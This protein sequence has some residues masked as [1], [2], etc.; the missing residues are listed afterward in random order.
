GDDSVGR[1]IRLV[2][3]LPPVPD[4]V[5]DRARTAVRDEWRATLAA[6]RRRRQALAGS[7]A[8]SLLIALGVG[9]WVQGPVEP[10]PREVLLAGL[11]GSPP[12]DDGTPVALGAML[13]AGDRLATTD[14]KAALDLP[15]GTSL[16]LDV[17]TSIRLVSLDDGGAVAIDLEHGAVY[18]DSPSA[19]ESDG[20][21]VLLNTPFG[22]LWDVG[23]QF[24]VRVERNQ[25]RLRV[26]EGRVDLVD[27][28]AG[29]ASVE[30]D[31]DAAEL[32]VDTSGRQE[33]RSVAVHGDVWRPYLDIA[34][35]PPL[36]G[37]TVAEVLTWVARE[38]GWTVIWRDP[39]VERLRRDTVLRGDF[40]G[41]PVHHLADVILPT[42]GLSAHLDD[43]GILFI[44][45]SR[46][47]EEPLP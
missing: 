1:L 31:V 18:V 14:G 5:V 13:A 11:T 30:A 28:P 34:P 32:T 9:W 19:S 35:P 42:C 17:A 33:R 44:D 10:P 41:V 39:N 16:R 23:T 22:R 4:A 29:D 38:T 8:A 43:D 7:L 25:L 47:I 15:D 24:E 27:S 37:A 26:R 21:S 45:S 20:P 12:N 2:A 36:D 3:D 40:A 6:R 46:S